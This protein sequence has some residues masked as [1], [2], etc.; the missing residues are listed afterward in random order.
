M[1]TPSSLNPELEFQDWGLVP[2]QQALE[3]QLEIVETVSLQ[4]KPGVLI[5]CSHPP[6]VT[7][8]RATQ[9]QDVFSWQGETLEVSR[10]GRATYHGPSQL[11]IYP[12]LNLQLERK[13]RKA[14]EI[15]GYLRTFENCIVETLKSYDVNSV[16]RSLQKKSPHAEG[17]DETGVWIGHQKIASLGIGVKKWVTYHGAAIN[18]DYDPLAFRGLNPCG[19]QSSTMISLE[20]ILNSPVD[21]DEFKRRLLKSLSADL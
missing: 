13:G 21:R 7:L 3:R 4:N 14:K 5:F 9:S 17:A 6:I 15:A 1:T 20:Q 10:G 12:I 19:F 11:V 18:L 8:G 16:G 2:Y